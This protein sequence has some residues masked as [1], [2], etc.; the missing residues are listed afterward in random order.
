MVEM[1]KQGVDSRP[2]FYPMSEMPYFERANTPVSHDVSA[3]GINLPTFVGITEEQI[4][5]VVDV[6]LNSLHSVREFAGISANQ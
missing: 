4:E 2:Y 5:R 1:K 6:F 3:C